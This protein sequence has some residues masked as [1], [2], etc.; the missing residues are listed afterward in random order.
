MRRALLPAPI[1]SASDGSNR[2]TAARCCS[3]KSATSS[4]QTQA[5]ILRVLQEQEFERLGGTRTLRVDVRFVAATHADLPAMVQ[6]GRF[7]EDLY[8][9]L[10]VVPIEMPTLRQ[11]RDDILPLAGSFVRALRGRSERAGRW[12]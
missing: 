12:L 6:A 8:Y 3:T 9:R 10:N 11:R 2:P 7:R 1:G 5:K 4:L